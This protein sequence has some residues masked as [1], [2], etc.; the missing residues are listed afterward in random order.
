MASLVANPFFGYGL[1]VSDANVDQQTK[2]YLAT[3]TTYNASL[4]VFSQTCLNK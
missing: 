1:D 3:F 2:S 4:F